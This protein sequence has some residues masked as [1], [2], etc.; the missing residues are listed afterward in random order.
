[1]RMFIQACEFILTNATAAFT[2]HLKALV[3]W[4]LYPLNAT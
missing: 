3:V 2:S 4:V 1:M